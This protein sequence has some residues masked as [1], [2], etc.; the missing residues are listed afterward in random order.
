[1]LLL[2]DASQIVSHALAHARAE[3]MPPMTVAVL[4]GRGCLIAY[5]SED[6]SSLLRE[7]IARAKAWGALGLGMGTRALAGRAVHHPAF[8]VALAAL[9]EGD[10]VPVPGGVLI[11][12]LSDREIVGA[13]GVS[14]HLPDHDEACAKV[15]IAAVGLVDDPGTA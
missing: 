1:M 7:R 12:T 2:A 13:V 4:D 14:G 8:F 15:G 10:M 3:K 11:R 9:A 5:Q 6:G